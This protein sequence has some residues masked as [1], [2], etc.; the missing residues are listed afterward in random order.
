[1]V[2]RQKKSS[3]LPNGR[4][5]H[6]S[7]ALT[8]RYQRLNDLSQLPLALRL[9]SY[10]A[11]FMYWGVLGGKW[12]RNHPHAHSFFEIC[13][14]YSGR[15]TFRMLDQ[16]YIVGAGDLFIAK[17]GELHEIVSSRSHPLGICFWAYTLVPVPSQTMTEADH[18]IDALMHAFSVSR[19]C[20][21]AG[22]AMSA[23]ILHLLAQEMADQLP[24]YTRAVNGLAAKLLLDTARAA[25]DGALPAEPIDSLPHNEVEAVVQIAARYLRDNLSR[26][27][28][29][30]DVAAQVHLSERHIS[31][32]F[33][34]VMGTS[35]LD[36]LTRARV[37][38]A[39]QLLLDREMS[40]KQVA[41]AVGYPD[42]HYFSTL[43]GRKTGL[44][45]GEFRSTGG[46]RFQRKKP[47]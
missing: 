38:T 40:V 27:V 16:S 10:R 21:C 26:P 30:R 29:V 37:D 31:R 9:G 17:P 2:R 8:R 41:R 6:S 5:D 7:G 25:T 13:Y 45:P 28:S 15:G 14:A 46:T 19:R 1:M 12:W 47:V 44:T 32:L 18:S 39:S 11:E 4:A 3:S 33:Q 42:A 34:R 35:I 22:G 23:A 43:F 36:Y 20:V 24:G